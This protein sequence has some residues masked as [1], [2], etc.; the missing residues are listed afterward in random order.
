MEKLENCPVCKSPQLTS[1]LLTKDFAVT[2]EEFNIDQCSHCGLRFT[3]PRPDISEIEKYYNSANYIS[4]TDSSQGLLNNVYQR[5]KLITL[6]QKIKL[7]K[8]FALNSHPIH[9][10]D[11]GC[12]TGDF[13]LTAQQ[14]GMEATG[15]E[16]A[17]RARRK[18]TEKGLKILP[19]TELFPFPQQ[20]FDVITLWHVLEH[21]HQLMQVFSQLCLVIKPK[22]Y[23][24]IALPNSDSTDATIYHE[25][26]AAFDVPRHLYHF[27]PETFNS[28][29]SHFP[30]KLVQ[31]QTMPFD[32]FYISLLSEK[33][34]TGSSNYLTALYNGL[35][36]FVSGYK[37][38]NRSSSVIYVLQRE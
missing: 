24:F 3:N 6:Q 34:K 20:N 13:L 22:G 2:K 28:F 4:H 33:Y 25:A 18:G 11:Y 8:E 37:E 27:T 7:V 15:I 26:W 17:E 16:P 14:A 12:G 9:L 30:V 21:V 32:P 35:T 38:V 36:G 23:F 31:K 29:I 19:E 1:Y 5:V 10:L